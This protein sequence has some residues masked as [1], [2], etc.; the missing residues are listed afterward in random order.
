MRIDAG[1]HRAGVDLRAVGQYDSDGA[2]GRGSDPLHLGFAAYFDAQVAARSF[3]GRRQPAHAALDVPPHAA[4]T[5][6]FAHH[7]VQ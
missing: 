5:A 7:V 1:G 4:R 6:G 3:D 2:T